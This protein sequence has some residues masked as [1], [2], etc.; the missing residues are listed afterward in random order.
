MVIRTEPPHESVKK[1]YRGCQS[2]STSS[3]HLD[4]FAARLDT[5]PNFVVDTAGRVRRLTFQPRDKVLAFIL[6]YQDR[7]LYGTDLHFS[8]GT[9]D[10]AAAESWENQYALDWRYFATDDTFE[11]LGSKVEGLNLPRPV[12]KKLYHDNAVRWI[13]GI[14]ASPR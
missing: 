7:I 5:Y 2:T 6:K 8:S 9:T 1:A 11:Y 4:D 3:N 10:S 14:D 13:P 12:L